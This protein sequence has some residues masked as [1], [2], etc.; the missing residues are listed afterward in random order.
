M[1][2][3]PLE[4]LQAHA[5]GRIAKKFVWL[6]TKGGLSL[7][8]SAYLKG[9]SCKP[10]DPKIITRKHLNGFFFGGGGKDRNQNMG[11]AGGRRGERKVQELAAKGAGGEVP[12]VWGAQRA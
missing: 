4:G 10:E 1:D 7:R 5:G 2:V 8:E 11:Q 9:W 12:C 6:E 3:A